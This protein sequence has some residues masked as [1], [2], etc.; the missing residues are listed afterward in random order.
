MSLSIFSGE[1]ILQGVRCHLRQGVRLAGFNMH[2]CA[3][4]YVCVSVAVSSARKSHHVCA[5]LRN[6]QHHH[7]LFWLLA[8]QCVSALPCPFPGH[9]VS[10]SA[11]R[12]RPIVNVLVLTR[13]NL[14]RKHRVEEVTAS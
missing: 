14:T 7:L 4:M 5:T 6:C 10:R 13:A 12:T 11:Q 9:H 1:A 2:G 8:N 3:V